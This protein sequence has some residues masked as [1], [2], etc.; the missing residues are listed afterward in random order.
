MQRQ[1]NVIAAVAAVAMLAMSQA[2]GFPDTI[3]M[4]NKAGVVIFSHGKHSALEN[5]GC[6]DCHHMGMDQTCHACHKPGAS[7]SAL[8]AREALH[9]QCIG[10]H[11]RETK[12]GKPSGPVAECKG[13]HQK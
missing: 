9:R 10:C 11:K 5:V 4:K 13:C 3:E 2:H 12:A 7:G 1:T 6:G 8:N